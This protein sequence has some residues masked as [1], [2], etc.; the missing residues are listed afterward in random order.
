M[1]YTPADIAYIQKA[2]FASSS[3]HVGALQRMIRNNLLFGEMFDYGAKYLPKIRNPKT[4][5]IELERLNEYAPEFV[6]FFNILSELPSLPDR[7]KDV[8]IE[9]AIYAN[10]ESV[11]MDAYY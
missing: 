11:Q 10:G 2:S 9:F 7:L 1:Q 3:K 8:A 4:G 5:K 6:E